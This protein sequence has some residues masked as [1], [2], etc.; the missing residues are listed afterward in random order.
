MS[1]YNGERYLKEA[2]DSILNQTFSDFEFIIINDGSTDRTPQILARLDNQRLILVH[3]ENQGLTVSL[4]SG[5]Q[6]ARGQHIA[7]MDADDISEPT[8]LERQVEL[9]DRCSDVA[10]VACWFKV[11]DEQGNILANRTIPEDREHLVKLFKQE[12]PLCH[13]SVLMRKE[14]I[15][16]V[17]FYNESLRYAQDYDLWLRMLRSGYKFDV[18]PDYL[19][20]FRISPDSVAKLYS[21][22]AYAAMIRRGWQKKGS[23]EILKRRHPLSKK[24]KHALYHYAIATFKLSE[25]RSRDARRALLKSLRLDPLNPRPW[26]RLGLSFFP[27]CIRGTISRAVLYAADHLS[28]FAH[29]WRCLWQR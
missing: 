26:Y 1:V 13:G 25:N 6:L 22:K 5:I 2:V 29:R 10:L 21:Q 14:A 9:L 16:T 19:Y 17:G 11:M 28:C 4:N 20:R 3:Q 7:R 12:N 27:P 8:R 18:V 23:D 24:Q 15:A